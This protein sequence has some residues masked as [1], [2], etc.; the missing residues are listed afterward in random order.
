MPYV[1]PRA[2]LPG[3]EDWEHWLLDAGL[4][5]EEAV[6]YSHALV[7]QDYKVDDIPNLS[8]F[9]LSKKPFNF[10]QHVVRKIADAIEASRGK[11]TTRPAMQPMAAAAGT[12]PG[13]A[14]ASQ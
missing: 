2:L 6:R 3:E 12:A 7:H 11:P 8:P 5:P 13:G 4:T 1:P 14:L 9:H 10:P